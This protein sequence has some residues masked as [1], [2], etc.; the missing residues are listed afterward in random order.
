MKIERHIFGSFSGYTTLAKSAGVSSDDCRM[1]ES[2][3]YGFGQSHDRGFLKSLGKGPAYFTR[4]MSGRRRGLTRVIEGNPDDNNRPTLCLITAIVSQDDW[5]SRLFGDVG[6]LLDLEKLWRVDALSQL[7]VLEVSPAAPTASLPRKNVAKVLALLSEVE[8]NFAARRTVIVAPDDYALADLRALEM[9]VP[10]AARRQ[11]TSAFRSLSGQ[12]AVS[13]NCLAAEAGAQGRAG[14]RYQP[15][16]TALS[17]YA[18]WLQASPLSEGTVPFEQIAGYRSFGA[19]GE[20]AAPHAWA[21]PAQ[22]T[23][24]VAP[25]A[26]LPAGRS[27]WPVTLAMAGLALAM[28]AGAFAA[29]RSIGTSST[30]VAEHARQEE[31]RQQ[32]QAEQQAA[33]AAALSQQAAAS[34]QESA[35]RVSRDNDKLRTALAIQGDTYDDLVAAASAKLRQAQPTSKESSLP[36][37]ALQAER[38]MLKADRDSLRAS[39]G[40]ELAR[41]HGRFDKAR[42][43]IGRLLKGL[44]A[45]TLNESRPELMRWYGEL[46]ALSDNWP[47]APEADTKWVSELRAIRDKLGE[48]AAASEN[49]SRVNQLLADSDDALRQAD[50]DNLQQVSLEVTNN[51]TELTDVLKLVPARLERLGLDLGPLRRGAWEHAQRLH[52]ALE[53]RQKAIAKAAEDGAGHGSGKDKD[54]GK[55]RSD[56]GKA[57]GERRDNPFASHFGRSGSGGVVSPARDA[58]TGAQVN[59][60]GGGQ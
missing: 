51:L 39:E 36:Q 9:L 15:G 56:G 35:A 28:A 23:A 6:P 57:D 41:Q 47:L 26:A 10:P 7:S 40:A 60:Q 50:A 31:E 53:E 55:S 49:L 21:S 44:T 12:L 29:G 33:Q 5:D 22:P 58:G 20:A 25:P 54:G 27:A 30:L 2:G 43:E 3:A 59:Q 14:F 32:L 46:S 37:T 34:S 52:K 1:L 11:F 18:D 24:P 42:I 17:P 45:A 19:G 8:R 13:V 16:T 48:L 38:D 4:L